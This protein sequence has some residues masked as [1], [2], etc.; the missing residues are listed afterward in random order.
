MDKY[1]W[2]LVQIARLNNKTLLESN[3]DIE[4]PIRAW[5]RE[6][7]KSVSPPR[8][9]KGEDT[10]G[11]DRRYVFRHFTY[12]S[13]S[14]LICVAYDY[15]RKD[16]VVFKFCLPA[17]PPAQEKKKK[18]T[19]F[20]K[21]REYVLNVY[22]EGLSKAKPHKNEDTERFKRGVLIQQQL[23]EKIRKKGLTELY[24]PAIYD[25]VPGGIEYKNQ[26]YCIMEL[27]DGQG[28]IEYCRD[29]TDQEVIELLYLIARGLENIVHRFNVVHSDIKPANI[30]VLNK[31]PVLLDFGISRV[32]QHAELT[33][34]STRGLGTPAYS[35]AEQLE[36]PL[37][38][39]FRDDIFALGRTFWAMW[40]RREPDLSDIVIEIG[41]DGR[42][43]YS[44]ESTQ[45]ALRAK[46]P[47]NIFPPEER[48]IFERAHNA[49]PALRYADISEFR[50]DVELLK[51]K[52]YNTSS[53]I[54]WIPY[55]TKLMEI[56][57]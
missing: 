39:S 38:R 18:K 15:Q 8:N 32:C 33:S 4:S 56:W 55:L 31:R 16:D 30:L 22:R 13:R 1:T 26:L 20:V 17:D 29:R 7:I 9:P 28:L 37:Q 6:L 40:A 46:F 57:Q 27:I 23:H 19:T 12:I 2:H 14:S 35:P 52:K 43:K 21:A 51:F 5:G 25:F 36:N 11:A 45:A 53:G 42:E 10:P 48:E 54:N 24:V 41:S 50:R 34:P 44:D 49:N 3:S 47:S